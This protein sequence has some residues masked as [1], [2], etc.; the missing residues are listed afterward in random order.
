MFCAF[1]I[2]IQIVITTNPVVVRV[3]RPYAG[4]QKPYKNI[5]DAVSNLVG[6]NKKA[7]GQS[8]LVCINR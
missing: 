4:V 8:D 5:W 1:S 7:V 2:I 3:G 6:E